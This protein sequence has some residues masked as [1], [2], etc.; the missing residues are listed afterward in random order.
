M[1]VTP[2][3]ILENEVFV[4]SEK[5]E[6]VGFYELK[7]DE[8]LAELEHLWINTANIGFGI[9]KKLFAHALEKAGSLN[10][11]TL[12]IKSDPNAEGFYN[13]MGAKRIGDEVSEIKRNKRILPL[14]QIV[15]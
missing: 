11:K 3:I 4:M 1:R 9:G 8:D 5:D 2:E 12:N 6:I 14:M 10:A 7:I 13:K 15:L